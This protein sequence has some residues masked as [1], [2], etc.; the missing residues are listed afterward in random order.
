MSSGRDNN[1]L[2]DNLMGGGYI[3]TQ[4]VERVFRVL[5]RADYMS[6][7]ARDQ[8]YKDLAWRNGLLH[9][10]APCIYRSLYLI[11]AFSST[12][13]DNSVLIYFTVFVISEVMEALELKP[14]L[15][16]LNL[17]SG[18]GYLSTLAGLILGP[19][20]ISH[21][22][23]C[24]P[25]VIEYANKKLGQFLEKSVTLD[26]FDFCFPKFY[27]GKWNNCSIW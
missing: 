20:G 18:T 3:R 2:I 24:Y 22:V 17:G 15:S 9:L 19:G 5:D 27:C 12:F 25:T 11:I 10:S 14:G 23:D 26:E 16:F 6:P 1:E 4:A 7:E 13:F 21:G 8:A